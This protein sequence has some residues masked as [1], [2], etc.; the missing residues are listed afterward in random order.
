M[1]LGVWMLLAGRNRTLFVFQDN[2]MWYI[3]SWGRRRELAPGQV[4]SVRL[5]ANRSIHRRDHDP[6]NG[7]AGQAGGTAGEH[8]P[9]A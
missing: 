3:S 1:L 6:R 9:M 7:K 8:R 5:T 4:A 2:S